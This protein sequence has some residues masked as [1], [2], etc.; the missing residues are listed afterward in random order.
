MRFQN[1]LAYFRK[2]KEQPEQTEEEKEKERQQRR[3]EEHHNSVL[4]DIQSLSNSDTRHLSN[5]ELKSILEDLWSS[6]ELSLTMYKKIKWIEDELS[7]YWKIDKDY[8]LRVHLEIERIVYERTFEF[9]YKWKNI[10]I[11]IK[12]CVIQF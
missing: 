4:S 11:E 10:K 5:N 3:N 9:L 1:I 6:M 12:P 8:D 2:K 7:S